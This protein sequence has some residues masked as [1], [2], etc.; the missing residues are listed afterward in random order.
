MIKTKTADIG[1]FS[2]SMRK[3]IRA[4]IKDLKD[5]FMGDINSLSDEEFWANFDTSSME[6]D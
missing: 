6:D 4:Q 1:M 3:R 5:T 2:R